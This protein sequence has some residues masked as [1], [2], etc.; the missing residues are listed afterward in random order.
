MTYCFYLR[1]NQQSN[2]YQ[3]TF[4]TY[5]GNASGSSHSDHFWWL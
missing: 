1:Q 2:C 4:C 3:I 5:C